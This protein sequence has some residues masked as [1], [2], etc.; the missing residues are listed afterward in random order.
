VTVAGS[1][2]RELSQY[3]TCHLFR[4]HPVVLLLAWAPE[5]ILSLP[6]D[7]T[8]ARRGL[9]FF[10]NLEPSTPILG[11]A[12]ARRREPSQARDGGSV[13]R[14]RQQKPPPVDEIPIRHFT[15]GAFLCMLR[16]I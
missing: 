7:I 3:S 13:R 16:K 14:N 10:G 15:W 1:L 12:E 5:T 9:L 4:N 6:E 11:G 8:C 2:R